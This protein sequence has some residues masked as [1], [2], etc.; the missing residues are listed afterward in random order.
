MGSL[1]HLLQKNY[2]LFFM[3]S[4]KQKFRLSKRHLF[5]GGFFAGL[6]VFQNKILSSRQEAIVLG[7]ILGDGH[8]QLSPNSKTTRLRFNHAMK[9]AHYVEWQFK[10]LGWLCDG[11]SKP[12]EIVEK[13]KYHIC[14]A[15][16]KY[17][18]ELTPYHTLTY[19]TTT[20]PNRRFVKTLPSNFGDYLK[21]PEVF[22]VWYLDDGTLRLDGGACRL[23]TQSFTLQEH[24][25]LQEALQNNFNVKTV[26]ETW[27]GGYSALYVPSR[28]GH[29]ADFVGLF[30][31]TIVKEIPSMTYK[32]Q[33]YV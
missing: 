7:N 30:S 25:I 33:R 10:E 9:Q 18:P 6:S 31:D 17:R 4:E 14:R 27:P 24:E 19:K 2:L 32:V 12:K 23:A 13:Q 28:G 20:L 21:N 22:M 1:V 15:Y 29:A 16:T 26:I 11:V 5:A 3:E 8:L